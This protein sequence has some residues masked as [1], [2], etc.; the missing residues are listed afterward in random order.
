MP[1][2]S[3]EATCFTEKVFDHSTVPG[4]RVRVRPTRRDAAKRPSFF[5]ICFNH[6]L[7]RW[8]GGSRQAID[9]DVSLGG[10]RGQQPSEASPTPKLDN[11]PA[12]FTAKLGVC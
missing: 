2:T 9:Q 11:D 12:I 8:M 1:S 6:E 4:R 7:G 10:G 3:G 5:S